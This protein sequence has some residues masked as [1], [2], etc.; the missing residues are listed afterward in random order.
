[1]DFLPPSILNSV[2]NDLADSPPVQTIKKE[3]YRFHYL[4]D[5]S[6]ELTYIAAVII[7]INMFGNMKINCIYLRRNTVA[8]IVLFSLHVL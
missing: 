2:K 7:L 5:S 3:K 4:I 1:M 6:V 8:E